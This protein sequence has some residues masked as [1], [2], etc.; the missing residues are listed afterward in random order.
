MAPARFESLEKIDNA[1]HAGEDDPVV[2][3]EM[4][5]GFI[6]TFIAIGRAD[7]NRRTED[8]FGAVGLEFRGEVVGLSEGS[9][10]YD[11]PAGERL[12]GFCQDKTYRTR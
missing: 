4:I 3:I 2:A 11:S 9:S 5:D 8:Y 10:D 7:F 1:I 6:Q 12:S